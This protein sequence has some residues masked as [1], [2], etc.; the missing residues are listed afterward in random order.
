MRK[1]KPKKR[2]PAPLTQQDTQAMPVLVEKVPPGR[3]GGAPALRITEAGWAHIE[4]MAIALCTADE[5][6]DALGIAKKTLYAG[7]NK[8][9]FTLLQGRKRAES[10]LLVRERQ[11]E[12]AKTGHPV[13]SIWFGKQHLGQTDRSQLTGKDGG[14]LEVALASV[15][16]LNALLDKLEAKAKQA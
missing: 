9:K 6:A 13:D 11:L 14:P 15:E 7:E 8:D 16:D 10:L 1:T 5:I 3:R 2:T 4:R 12:K